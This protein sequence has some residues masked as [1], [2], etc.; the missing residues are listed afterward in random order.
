VNLNKRPIVSDKWIESV[1]PTLD[2][3]VNCEI[4][5][6]DVHQDQ[7]GRDYDWRTN[8]GGSAEPTVLYSGEA[9]FQVYRF[10]LTMD[11][12]VGSVDQVRSGRF[13]LKQTAD[14]AELN[15][16]KGQMIRVTHAPMNPSLTKFQYNINS[17]LN[18]GVPFRRTIEVEIDMA[19]VV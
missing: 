16:R 13:T 7:D 1:Q 2:G 4:E 17:G 8:T 12:P 3:F 5:I 19:R 10:T 6:L 15:I 18:S 9:Q 11:A 14:V